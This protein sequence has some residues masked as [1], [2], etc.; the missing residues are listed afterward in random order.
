MADGSVPVVAQPKSWV[1][2]LVEGA[3]GGIQQ[4]PAKTPLSY[5]REAGSLTGRF[6]QA[7]GVGALLGAA[8]AKFGLD[9]K[10]GPVDGWAAALGWIFGI[11]LSGHY[12]WLAQRLADGGTQALTVLSFRKAFGLVGGQGMTPGGAQAPLPGIPFSPAAARFSGEDPIITAA[13]MARM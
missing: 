11:G 13:K 2:R 12:P 10:A 8:H 7:G 1:T 4:A 6:V 9:T 3:T 5:V